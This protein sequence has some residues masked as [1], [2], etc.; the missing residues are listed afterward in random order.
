MI[1]TTKLPFTPTTRRQVLLNFLLG[2]RARWE[3]NGAPQSNIDMLSAQIDELIPA[4]LKE[5]EA[6]EP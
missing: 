6:V 4:V 2:L 1:D 3:D 5:V